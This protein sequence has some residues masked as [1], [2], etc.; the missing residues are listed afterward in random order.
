[1]CTGSCFRTESGLQLP[2]VKIPRVAYYSDARL[3]KNIIAQ[4]HKCPKGL[5][6]LALIISFYILSVSPRMYIPQN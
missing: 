6:M 2:L 5:Y 1:M 3:L 4:T